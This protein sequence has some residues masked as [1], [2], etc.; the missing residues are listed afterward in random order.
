MESKYIDDII[1]RAIEFADNKGHEYVTTE[2][3]LNCV[4]EE[5]SVIKICKELKINVN[6]IVND[7]NLY[8][9]DFDFN[10]LTNEMVLKEIP[11][12]Q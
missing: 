8:L 5:K 9:D 7:L 12:K 10:G 3:I 1:Q 6:A 2:H 11:K 4:L